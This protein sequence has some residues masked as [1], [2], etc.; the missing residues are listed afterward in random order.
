MKAKEE[1]EKLLIKS[2]HLKNSDPK[3]MA[4]YWFRE[5]EHRGLDALGG[6]TSRLTWGDRPGWG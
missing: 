5:L 6:K 2:P 1:I 4:T 3:L